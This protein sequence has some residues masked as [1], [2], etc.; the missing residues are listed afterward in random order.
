MDAAGHH[1]GLFDTNGYSLSH[2]HHHPEQPRTW[3][4]HDADHGYHL[5]DQ[6]MIAND[7]TWGENWK[8]YDRLDYWGKDITRDGRLNDVQYGEPIKN[9][10]DGQSYGHVSVRSDHMHTHYGGEDVPLEAASTVAYNGRGS[11]TDNQWFHPYKRAHGAEDSNRRNRMRHYDVF[12]DG[13][14]SNAHSAHGLYGLHDSIYDPVSG[15]GAGHYFDNNFHDQMNEHMHT[16]SGDNLDYGLTAHAIRTRPLMLD[17]E[18]PLTA[19]MLPGGDYRYLD[20]GAV[21]SAGPH[22]HSGGVVG[23]VGHV[24]GTHGGPHGEYI[25]GAWSTNDHDAEGDFPFV[26]TV[27]TSGAGYGYVGTDGASHYAGDGHSHDQPD[28]VWAGSRFGHQHDHAHLNE[29]QHGEPGTQHDHHGESLTFPSSGAHTHDMGFTVDGHGAQFI[30]RD[31]QF[32]Q[33]AF[34]VL[35]VLLLFICIKD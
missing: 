2:K 10:Y 9:T 3:D 33:M 27:G 34:V 22:A 21:G 35:A 25:N 29:N 20:H 32:N 24:D 7:W 6:N 5:E 14:F 1:S 11:M 26:D 12:G 16:L 18:N 4:H 28:H 17:P 23:S 31:P 13:S 19:A 8:P 30:N 15:M